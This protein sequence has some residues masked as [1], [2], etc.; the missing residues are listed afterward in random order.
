MPLIAIHNRP[1]LVLRRAKLDVLE[2]EE[3]RL[4]T[5]IGAIG[6]A[7]RLEIFFGFACDIP[8]IARV[9][10]AARLRDVTDEAECGLGGKR[11]QDRA[12]GVGHQQHV[13]LVDLLEAADAGA[14][15][16][17]ALAE[18]RL[19]Q[20]TGGDAEMLPGAWHVR[21]LKVN[22]AD[23]LLA[24]HPYHFVSRPRHSWLLP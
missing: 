6:D 24:H 5:E 22:H 19:L 10:S 21:E 15:K 14:I 7:G 1:L 9:G 2:D 20:R 17:N 13:A 18:E 16:A 3:L 12:A 23:A 4:G 8:R 11:I